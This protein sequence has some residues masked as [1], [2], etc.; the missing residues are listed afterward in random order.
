MPK[1]QTNFTPSISGI[2]AV[3][4]LTVGS[5]ASSSVTASDAAE[6]YSAGLFRLPRQKV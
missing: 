4:G 5:V 1:F 3:S 2:I 6:A